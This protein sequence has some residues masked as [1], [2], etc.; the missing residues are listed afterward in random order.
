[1]YHPH[2]ENV[3]KTSLKMK[4]GENSCSNTSVKFDKYSILLLQRITATV[5]QEKSVSK[6]LNLAF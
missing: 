3:K 4:K 2:W 5:I 6:G 1:M